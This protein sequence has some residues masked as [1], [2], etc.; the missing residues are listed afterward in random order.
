MKG[1][2]KA[3]DYYLTRQLFINNIKYSGSQFQAKKFGEGL[4]N[5]Y[6]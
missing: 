3:D 5:L 2:N 4:L 6:V 1:V